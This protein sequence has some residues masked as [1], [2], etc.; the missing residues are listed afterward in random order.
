MLRISIT[1]L[2]CLA[3]S[4]PAQVMPPGPSGVSLGHLHFHSDNPAAHAKF[5]TDV[6]G[7]Q[8]TKV[9][10]LDVY[11]LPGFFI[12]LNHEKPAGGM[13]GS[14]VPSIGLKVRDLKATLAKAKAANARIADRSRSHAVI[15]GPDD[16]RIEL[17]ADRKLATAV[18][19]DTIQLSLPDPEAARAWYA[20]TFGAVLGQG[21]FATLPGVKLDFSKSAAVPAGTKGHVLDHIG[22]EIRDLREFTRKLAASGQKVDLMYYKLPDSGVA[23]GFVTDPWGTYIELTEG[24][25]RF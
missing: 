5:W 11:K 19:S 9:G 24:L 20:K 25:I 16:I 3:L 6:F 12:A 7:A 1:A 14:T 8:L 17:T 13:A 10:D 15:F 2:F 4:L 23:I 18:A 21:D 22:L